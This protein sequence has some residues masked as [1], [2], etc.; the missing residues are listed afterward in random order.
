M[1]EIFSFLV[2]SIVFLRAVDTFGR[3][4]ILRYNTSFEQ[5]GFNSTMMLMLLSHVMLIDPLHECRSCRVLEGWTEEGPE[6]RH[7]RRWRCR[8]LHKNQL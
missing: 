4:I 3:A 2:S 1:L 8:V 5:P 7:A 6:I